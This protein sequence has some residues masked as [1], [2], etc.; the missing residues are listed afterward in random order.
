VDEIARLLG[1]AEQDATARRHAT[2][3]L[4]TA[5]AERAALRRTGE[6]R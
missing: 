2:E 1:A 5:T 6:S 4:E 3:M